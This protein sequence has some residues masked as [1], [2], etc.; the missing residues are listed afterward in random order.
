MRDM[1]GVIRSFDYAAAVTARKSRGS[2]GAY[3]EPEQREHFLQDFVSRAT[4]VFLDSYR[5]VIPER[6]DAASLDLFLIEKAA[7]EI[8]Y[9]AAN[10]P[11]WI[12]VPLHGLA[13]IVAELRQERCMMDQVIFDALPLPPDMID[14]LA[15]ARLGDP[16]TAAWSARYAPG[17]DHP[18]LSCRVRTAW[19]SSAARTAA[20]SARCC[21]RSRW[22]LFAGPGRHRRTLPVAY[23]LARRRAGD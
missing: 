15:H 22:G 2:A 5:E 4:T 21:R 1:A 9:E 3:A 16:F 13:R 19:M 10:R 7:Y 18:R 6:Q 11:A 17:P 23:S 8:A 12:D 20:S 14:A